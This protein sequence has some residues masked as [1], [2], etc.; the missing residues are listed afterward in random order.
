M[1][2]KVQQNEHTGQAV[3]TPVE[4]FISAARELAHSPLGISE[5]VSNRN[6]PVPNAATLPCYLRCNLQ[7]P[8]KKKK[9]I[10][11]RAFSTT[12]PPKNIRAVSRTSHP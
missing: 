2:P 3:A 6:D 12:L 7:P 4:S 8:L 10:T 9:K 1:Y 11:E 5:H